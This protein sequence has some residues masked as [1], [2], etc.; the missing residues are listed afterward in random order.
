[1]MAIVLAV[2]A[3]MSTHAHSQTAQNGRREMPR[4]TLRFPAGKS[5]VEV[6][7]EVESGWMLIPVSVNGSRPLRYV[8]DSGSSGVVHTN[9]A[10]VESLNL[11]IAGNMQVRGAGGGG[12]TSEVSVAENVTFDIGGIELSNGSLAIHPSLGSGFDGVIG[13]PIF[14]NLVVE[15]DWEKQVIRF[16]EPAK[17]KYCGSGTVLPLTFD[18]GG[19][20]YAMASVTATN[21]KPIPVKLV[22]DTGGSHTLSLDV[23]SN[24]EIKLPEGAT[25][26]VLGRGGSGEI[27]GYAGRIN[28]LDLGGQTFKDVP[29]IFPDSSSGTA[30][31]N[32]RQG[33]L[34]SGILR[35]FKVVYD[36]SR[37]QMIVEPNK[38][39]ND[40][41]GTV[42]QHTAASSVPIAPARLPDYTG[43]YG[44]KEISVK[45]GGLY[46]QR[47]GGS[48]AALRATGKDKFA[49]NADA[50][51]TFVRDANGVVSEMVIEWVD[52]D[53]E[54]LKR[55]TSAV[56]PPLTQTQAAAPGR[57]AADDAAFAKELNTFLEQASASDAFSGAVLVARNG[58]P[59]FKK[60]YGMANKSNSTPNNVDTKFDLG[61]MNKMFTAVAITQLV[62]RGKL[63]FTDTVGKLLP[64]YPNKQVAEKVTV[65]QLLTHTSGMGSYFNGK[66]QANLNN[67][68]TVADYLPL[69]A[70]EPLAFEPGSKWQ[71][72]N[73]GFVVLG[74]IIEKV[75]GQSYFDYVKE[76]IFKPAGMVNTDSYESDHD[77]SNL[78]IGY[79]NMGENGRPDPSA[80]RRPNT[81][82][83]ALRG[84]PAGGGYSTV[85][86]MLR[87]SVALQNHKLLSKKYTEIVT[88][89]KVEMAGPERKYAYGFGEEMSNG[90]RIVGH[91]GGGPG[92]GTNFDMFPELGYTAVILGNY[93]PPAMMPV[94]KKIRDLLPTVTPSSNSAQSQPQ[95]ISQSEQEVRKLERE[96]LDAYEQHDAGAMDRILADDFKLT[97]SGGAAQ[98]KADILAALKAPRDSG[99][100]EPKFSTDDVQS[101]VE[102]DTVILTGRFIQRMERDGQMRTMEARYAD[103]YAKRQGRW[104]VV[105]SQLTRIPQ[106]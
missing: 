90:R 44:N 32:G 71:Y 19:R 78:A 99:R 2:L 68:K 18:E 1:V 101:R 56:T 8:L 63:S 50:Q 10:M 87:F 77:V 76:H 100:P 6:P 55:E 37:K 62:E 53:K 7:F 67:L 46:Y 97:Q 41:F 91:N 54:Q 51:I 13:R 94:V 81:P 11:K 34:G 22:V 80:P 93:D 82:M 61:S 95:P 33:N 30:G 15:V 4:P 39:S 49:L 70:D 96:W 69:F 103:T 29:T 83:R 104:Q 79:M 17:Y 52:R 35:R 21:E 48:G 58:Q 84:S 75:S 66:F 42:M 28:T 73:S 5:V 88:T 27:T 40:P 12:A 20:P 64:D 85:D 45:D 23:G 38:F 106:Q 25:K 59:I 98:T 92:I 36:Y 86:D 65:H 47:I 105:A 14:A 102:G 43:K 74:L 16:Y 72:S 60:A 57:A 24:S 9:A 3:S 26:T 89:G 31:L